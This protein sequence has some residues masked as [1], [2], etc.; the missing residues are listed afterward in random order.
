MIGCL[1][2]GLLARCSSLVLLGLFQLEFKLVFVVRQRATA[3]AFARIALATFF[4]LTPLSRLI[5]SDLSALLNGVRHHFLFLKSLPDVVP[6]E[7]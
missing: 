7:T 1:T 6:V 3:Y 4:I 2:S 5:L